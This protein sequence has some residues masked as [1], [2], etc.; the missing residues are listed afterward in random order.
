MEAVTSIIGRKTTASEHSRFFSS[1]QE[2]WRSVLLHRL[3]TMPNPTGVA[4]QNAL[5]PR[6]FFPLSP[7]QKG[8]NMSSTNAKIRKPALK[9][10]E[11][12]RA[13]RI[14]D[15][16]QLDRY[17][18]SC[19]LWEDGFYVDGATIADRIEDVCSRLDFGTIAN[20]AMKAR[21]V[22]NLR[23]V[24]LFLC[25]QLLKRFS[26]RG[27]EVGNIISQILQRPDELTELLAL[28]WKDG[29][30]PLAKQLK[31]AL[32]SALLRF[33]EYALAKYNRPKAVKLR[34]VLFLSHAKPVGKKQTALFKRL[35]EDTLKTPDTWEVRLSS[36]EDKKTAFEAL[37]K[38]SKLGA[39]AVLRNLRNM[40]SAGV[41][42]TL[43][44]DYIKTMDV[45]RVLPFR[46]I[47]AAKYAPSLE[48]ALETSLFKSCASLPRL[49]GKTVILCD[50]SGS[51]GNNISGKSEIKRADA[52][53]AL[54]AILRECC[55][56]VAVFSF[57]NRLYVL[58]PRRGFALTTLLY[59]K[60][61][62]TELGAALRYINDHEKYDRI[63]VITDEQ[64][65]DNVPAPTAN[66]SYLINV[67]VD[68]NG[69][70]YGSPWT[71]I[72]GFSDQT[73]RFICELEGIKSEEKENDE[74]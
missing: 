37:L 44:R 64:T 19:L 26:G 73:V 66:L 70:G 23:H 20:C 2:R 9:T 40:Q 72:D 10:E 51:M 43:L 61:E 16:Q 33:D 42:D 31:R 63:V 58:P 12:G 53:A 47:T 35:A 15:A 24:P 59:A 74:E 52:S 56:A 41:N 69:V 4:A 28:Y 3:L 14:S 57:G 8:V 11:G 6:F 25:L 65:K 30:K 38:E 36:G 5:L 34:D 1:V 50:V 45:R 67:G 22:M 48:D 71:H 17:V 62:G 27:K 46:F 32:A 49:P 21:T 60:N 18:M 55:E 68:K 7:K 39:L 54:A 13:R 29:K